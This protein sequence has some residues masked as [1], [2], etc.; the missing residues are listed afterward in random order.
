[1]A[2]GR[3]KGRCAVRIVYPDTGLLVQETGR[4]Q[5]F[6][7]S[8]LVLRNLFFPLVGCVFPRPGLYLVQFRFEK[9]LLAQE[10]LLVR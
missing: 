1:M 8:P 9:A 2:N 6:G 5:T 4:D 7:Q 10:P 3:G